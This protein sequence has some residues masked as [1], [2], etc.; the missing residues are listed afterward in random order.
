MKAVWV[1]DATAAARSG[2]LE[3]PHPEADSVHGPGQGKT[4]SFE[5]LYAFYRPRIYNL[6][7]RTLHDADEA[8]DATQETFLKA[9]R[10]MPR[11]NGDSELEPWLYRV[12]VNTCFDHLRARRRRP[13]TPLAAEGDTASPTDGFAQAETGRLVEETLKRLSERH[14]VAL[15]LKDLHGFTHEEI[16]AVLGISR[17]AAETLLFRARESFRSI[18]EELSPSS[19][20]RGDGCAY[21]RSVALAVV[22]RDIS[23][24]QR[25]ELAEHAKRCPACRRSLDLREGP[26]FGLGLFVRQLAPPSLTGPPPV[27]A[28][29]TPA[30]M[31]PATAATLGGASSAGVLAKVA[32]LLGS[33]T[34]VAAAVAAG[35]T[36]A[37]G[38][39]A[40]TQL[41]RGDATRPR[42]TP[43][44]AAADATG[45]AGSAR[46]GGGRL[47]GPPSNGARGR[48]LSAHARAKD[49]AAK[50]EAPRNAKGKDDATGH[51]RKPT[52]HPSKGGRPD[53]V[54]REQ[55][56]DTEHK[57]KAIPARGSR[58]RNGPE[59]DRA[60]PPGAPGGQ[61]G[62]V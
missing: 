16:A 8:E 59:A 24:A 21:A 36:L 48:S 32:V 15:V 12:A 55:A 10:Q 33:K 7:L 49:K 38:T 2:R 60:S 44:A 22:G 18:F 27:P 20:P 50:P 57:T 58:E 29:A 14:R 61:A 40:H 3:P 41:D 34:A 6:A 9:F 30:V 17:G 11:Q 52:A 23:P 31:A 54:G 43:A 35:V 5:L 42:A 19:S 53:G 46:A 62:P 37:G 39:A 45:N 28:A 1:S 56:K 25:R 51:G 13:T 26:A 4:R 47:G